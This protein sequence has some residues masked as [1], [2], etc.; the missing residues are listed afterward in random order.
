MEL[1]AP[2]FL[3]AKII[4]DLKK[5]DR[6]CFRHVEGGVCQIEG[7][8]PVKGGSEHQI[9]VSCGTHLSIPGDYSENKHAIV[10]ERAYRCFFYHSYPKQD[11][12][13][14]TVLKFL[15]P[16]DTLNIHW[17]RDNYNDYSKAKGLHLDEVTL[18]VLRPTKS[19]KYAGEKNVS[20]FYVGNSLTPDNSARIVTLI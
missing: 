13:I 5:A 2:T 3:T 19:R 16:G 10:H 11:S 14:C 9:T 17:V 12:K 15:R 8:I 4:A 18:E 7:Y 20:A 6:L 1:A